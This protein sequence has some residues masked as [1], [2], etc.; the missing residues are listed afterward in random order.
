[1]YEELELFFINYVAEYIN[2]PLLAYVELKKY[3]ILLNQQSYF[4]IIIKYQMS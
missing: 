4:F 3:E 1:M 2:R